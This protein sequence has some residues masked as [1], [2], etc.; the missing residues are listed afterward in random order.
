MEQ[1]EKQMIYRTQQQQKTIEQHAPQVLRKGK[2]FL[3]WRTKVSL[4]CFG[5]SLDFGLLLPLKNVF[6]T[7]YN[8]V[9]FAN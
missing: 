2:Q 6:R 4:S 3:E 1:G 7:K 9:C 8:D 5:V